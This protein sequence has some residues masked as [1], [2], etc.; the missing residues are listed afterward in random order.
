[1]W[2]QQVLDQLNQLTTATAKL[3][4]ELEH[5]YVGYI[6]LGNG[7]GIVTVVTYVTNGTPSL[8]VTLLGFISIV[9]FGSGITGASVTLIVTYMNF[10][11]RV[12]D[13]FDVADAIKKGLRV[14]S[15]G[16]VGQGE[17][18][19][20]S[21]SAPGHCLGI[22]DRGLSDRSLGRHRCLVTRHLPELTRSITSAKKPSLSRDYKG[23]GK[24]CIRQN[25][26]S[27]LSIT[28]VTLGRRT[29]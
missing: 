24:S 12:T 25:A 15:D 18:D 2:S 23:L 17:E 21:R 20:R 10:H 3:K 16:N 28:L 13:A 7:A 9:A 4:T 1:M 11:R 19:R 22:V 6:L 5:R 27:A 8:L 26:T 29:P 14:R